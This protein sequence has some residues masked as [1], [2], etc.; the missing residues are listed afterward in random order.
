MNKLHM[1]AHDP[2]SRT[3][4]GRERV[5]L[6]IAAKPAEQRTCDFCGQIHETPSGRHYLYRYWAVSDA[7]AKAPIDGLFCDAECMR[8]YTGIRS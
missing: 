1:F 3:S 8:A 6:G 5:Y 7:G 2:F 4:F